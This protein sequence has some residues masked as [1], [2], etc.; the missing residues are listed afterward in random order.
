MDANKVFKDLI[1]DGCSNINELT[2][3][4]VYKTLVD[5]ENEVDKFISFHFRD[6]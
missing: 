1:T 4:R 5:R 6:F 2:A 3:E